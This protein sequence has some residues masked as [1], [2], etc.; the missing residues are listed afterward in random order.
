MKGKRRFGEFNYWISV[1]IWVLT[2]LS[3]ISLL[4]CTAEDYYNQGINY[5]QYSQYDQAIE[6][7]KKALKISSSNSLNASIYFCLA[8]AYTEI[9]QYDLAIDSYKKYLE[10]NPNNSSLCIDLG[11]VYYRKGQYDLAID[12]YKK[13]L[14]IRS[15]NFIGYHDLGN[16]YYRKG[17]YD[18]AIDSYRKSLEINPD[19][20][21]AYY[22]LGE[23]Y[24]A[25]GQYDLAIDN[26]R[27]AI[28]ISPKIA[29]IYASTSKIPF[30][31]EYHEINPKLYG[32][33]TSKIPF[34]G[35]HHPFQKITQAEEDSTIK[36]VR[37]AYAQID[38]IKGAIY[39]KETNWPI[40]FGSI[41]EKEE[42]ENS[43]KKLDN[44]SL[45]NLDELIMCMKVI[46][47]GEDPGVSIE[48]PGMTSPLMALPASI[49]D[50]QTVRYIP[51]S[52]KGTQLGK[53]VFE[54]DRALKGLGFG[55]DPITHREVS[56]RI[57]G[58]KTLPERARQL[59]ETKEGYF[60]RIWFKP[61]EV[62]L[63]RGEDIV[64][65]D[66]ITIKVESESPYPTPSQFASHFEK[67]YAEFSLALPIY[68]ELRRIGKEVAIARW[69]K[70]RYP[71]LDLES[72]RMQPVYT[73]SKTDTLKGV[74]R[75]EIEGPYLKVSALIGGVI[76]DVRN[77][78]EDSFDLENIKNLILNARANKT[79]IVWNFE[80]D[81]KKYIAV[82][83]PFH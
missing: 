62:S 76:Y 15:D 9:G 19:Y 75:R 28:E 58:Y 25:K 32:I 7:C 30:Y 11:N 12:S 57:A 22:H 41:K 4:G 60:G 51:E 40:I 27:K 35:E 46:Q 79:D 1:S 16:V 56:S 67:H 53:K 23:A 49:P 34:S 83:L 68:R 20:S 5:Y 65:F 70:E 52:I 2:I 26:Y 44:Q 54:A 3:L 59:A 8:H 37:E 14:E 63:K 43:Q 45:M 13:A 29:K 48:P 18:Q 78:Y 39:D 6:N 38:E 82:A 66:K 73:P 36:Q 50:Y 77:Q 47:S 21:S 24:D 64:E 33:D 74:I 72:Y 31:E 80:I 42:K 10:I 61:K 55:E 71:R 81:N 69:L 17:Q